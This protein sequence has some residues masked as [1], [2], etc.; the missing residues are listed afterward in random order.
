MN[1]PFCNTGN[2][3]VVDSR[4]K[5]GGKA[6]RRRRQ[7]SRCKNRFTTYEEV[8]ILRLTVI[9]RSGE[10]EEYNRGKIEIGLRKALEKRPVPE[11]KIQE[12]LSSI[13]YEIHSKET[14][15]IKSRDIGKII[16]K[17]LQGVDEVGYLR[18]ASVYKS[19]GSAESFKKEAT[20][21]SEE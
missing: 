14:N 11:A 4:S 19:F 9:K 8:E 17:K 10:K 21:I 3:R 6:I 18:F 20:R 2:T 15:K 5:N 7:C 1:C 13:E 12:L 16:L